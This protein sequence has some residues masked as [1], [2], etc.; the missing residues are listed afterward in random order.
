MSALRP[1][2]RNP[3]LVGAAVLAGA[4]ILSAELLIPP[5]LGL[6]NNGDFEKVMG[7]AGIQ[8]RETAYNDKYHGHVVQTFDRV[9]PGWY[10]SGYLS[11]ETPLALAARAG[12]ELFEGAGV[13]DIR[14]LGALQAAILL[15]GLGTL[16]AACRD[17]SWLAQI[18]AA[19]LLVLV[20]TDVGYAAPFNSFYSQSASLL[21][22]LATLAAAALAVRRG[23]LDGGLLVVYFLCA[24]LF[25][26]SK[27]QESIQAPILAA[28][29]WRL[30]GVSRRDWWRRPAAGLALALCLFSLAYYRAIQRD[31]VRRAGLF[32]TVFL[33]VLTHSPDPA[34]DLAELGLDPGLRVYV[35]TNAF[36]PGSPV[37]D[38]AFDARF[39]QRFDFGTLVRFYLRHPLRLADRLRR[40][41]PAAFRLRTWRLGN[42]TKSS[43]FPPHT[44][45]PHF[46]L[47]SDAR[48]V[49]GSHAVPPLLLFF[50]ANATLCLFGWR[51][52]PPRERLALTALGA[53]LVMAALEYLVCALADHLGDLPRHL[54]VF[55][56]LCDLVLIADLTWLAQTIAS[57]RA[58]TRGKELVELTGI[59]PASADGRRPAADTLNPGALPPNP[60][61]GRRFDPATFTPGS[62]LVMNSL[63][64]IWWS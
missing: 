32:D 24:A 62:T 15:A 10:R 29:G 55:Q 19:A 39:F 17:L 25:V 40:G 26:G 37:S 1:Q 4:A 58:R 23:R 57:R 48:L 45:T 16:V 60:R 38:P 8:Y 41:A 31:A 44:M 52:T 47:W 21:F 49:L 20:F 6:A 5:I 7:Y 13:F 59:E 43:G 14:W 27:P 64:G 34:A 12:S 11:S 35:G 46:A 51:R 33:D 3:W 63:S 18:V 42:Y 22:V 28:L 50:T 36:Q 54:Y 9:R 2:T 30:A 56:A 61:L 53:V